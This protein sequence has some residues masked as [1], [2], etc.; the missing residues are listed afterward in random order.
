M[1]E[2]AC[3]TDP[4]FIEGYTNHPEVQNLFCKDTPLR[5]EVECFITG[6]ALDDKPALQAKIAQWR[7]AWCVESRVEGMHASTVSATSG[8]RSHHSEA[9]VP[10]APRM[11][12]MLEMIETVPGFWPQFV[13]HLNAVRLDNDMIAALGLQHHPTCAAILAQMRPQS[14][15]SCKRGRAIYHAYEY[16][17]YRMH[18]PDLRSRSYAL[19]GDDGLASGEAAE[20]E[21]RSAVVAEPLGPASV[22]DAEAL[23]PCGEV[24]AEP[25][26]LPSSLVAQPV[27]DYSDRLVEH[28]VEQHARIHVQEQLRHS[29]ARHF[30]SLPMAATAL[31][32]V[33][34]ATHLRSTASAA[35][36]VE[37]CFD[38]DN[39][40]WLPPHDEVVQSSD[41]PDG[42]VSEQK[43]GLTLSFF[44]I[45][46]KNLKSMKLGPATK[47][48]LASYDFVVTVH[49]AVDVDLSSRHVLVSVSPRVQRFDLT[50]SAPSLLLSTSAL[51]LGGMRQLQRWAEVDGIECRLSSSYM[52]LGALLRLSCTGCLPGSSKRVRSLVPP[53][54]SLSKG[55]KWR[56]ASPR[57]WC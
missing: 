45:V 29:E 19:L 5:S 47:R 52:C 56:L 26:A 14:H 38:A 22:A 4:D 49:D 25:V 1:V 53:Q 46:H 34:V 55:P 12:E 57:P 43:A 20:A 40:D 11:P 17:L 2:H 44:R 37:F 13:E 41:L 8:K 21:P 48:K 31:G 23:E 3:N 6:E 54:G 10:L 33:P 24:V 35:D 39:S 27:A 28:L 7:M 18:V 15:V 16:T 30:L 32:A 36:D 42:S 9:F 50:D 51:D